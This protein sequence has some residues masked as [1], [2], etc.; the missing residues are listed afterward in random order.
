MKS[1]AFAI[2]IETDERTGDVMAVYLKFRNG[3]AARS[4][5]LVEGSAFAN[6]DAKGELIGVELLAPCEVDVLT[7]LSKQP[8]VRKFIKRTLPRHAAWAHA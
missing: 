7:R 3:K 4:E 1:Y 6:Y 5:E 8:P 2:S